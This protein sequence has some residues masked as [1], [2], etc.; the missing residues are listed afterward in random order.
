MALTL[1]IGNLVHHLDPVPERVL[2]VEPL[3]AALACHCVVAM[4]PVDRVA[5]PLEPGRERL[6]LGGALDRQRGVRPLERAV[7][8]LDT[9]V[10]LGAALAAEP[11]APASGEL[12]RLLDLGEAQAVAV[13]PPAVL[14]AAG[15]DAH[16]DVVQPH[17]CPSVLRATAKTRRNGSTTCPFLAG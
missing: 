14:L 13:E 15:R 1:L 3:E 9:E 17:R 10:D 6:Q 16:L 7:V 2:G 12:G 11:G 5:E 8:P 4:G